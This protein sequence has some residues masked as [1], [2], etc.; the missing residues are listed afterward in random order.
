MSGIGL[1]PTG[2]GLVDAAAA[3]GSSLVQPLTAAVAQTAGM[4][5][6][7]AT[8]AGSGATAQ[9]METVQVESGPTGI[10]RSKTDTSGGTAG[11]LTKSVFELYFI[12]SPHPWNFHGLFSIVFYYCKCSEM[13]FLQSDNFM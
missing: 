3:G 4:V 9:M 11:T 10:K 2:V 5:P 13:D 8:S 12:T 1:A 7:V 6:V